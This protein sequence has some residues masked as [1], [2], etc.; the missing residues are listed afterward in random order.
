MTMTIPFSYPNNCKKP[1]SICVMFCSSIAG[2]NMDQN[3]ENTNISHYDIGYLE[4]KNQ[5]CV[6]GSELYIDDIELIY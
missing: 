4:Y 1:T 3:Y 6:T 2:K 5:A